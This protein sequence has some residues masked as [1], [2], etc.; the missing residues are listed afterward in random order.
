MS[1]TDQA[2]T[3]DAGM[4]GGPPGPHVRV[5]LAISVVALAVAVAVA[6][7]TSGPIG[8]WGLFP[9]LVYAVLVL[10]EFNVLLATGVALVVA[11]VISRT[12]PIAVGSLL[13]ESLGSFIAVVGLIIMLGAGLGRVA[14]ETGAARTLVTMLLRG[15]G[16]ESPARAQVGIMLASTILVGALGTLSGANAI[17]A[18]LA[19]PVA[20]AVGR[21]KPSVAVMLHS[22]GAA[23]LVIGPFTPPVVTITGASELSYGAYLLQVGL[24]MAVVVWGVGF[25]MARV[26]HRRTADDQYPA[27]LTAGDDLSRPIE[28][29][30]RRAAVGFIGSLVLM[31]ILGVTIKAG[32]SYAIVVM[33]VATVVT[34]LAGSMGVARALQAFFA[35]AASL[36]WLFFLFWMFNPL[37]VVMEESGAYQ[38]VVD[39]AQPFM[40]GV[41]PW[42]F[43]MLVLL[44]GWIGI[45]GAAVAQ[46]VLIDKLFA[47]I[48]AGLGIPPVAWAA[49]LL[50]GS[51]IDWFGPLPN[52]DMIGQM[53]LARSS[54]LRMMLLNGWTIMGCTLLLF[55][56]LF[57]VVL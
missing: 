2:G 22:A 15:V 32:F 18:P 45:S 34:A 50:G 33:L 46:V 54:N 16:T 37:L 49:A 8:L 10:I 17:L 39:A 29:R 1:S 12:G 41:G 36:I 23:G 57:L 43:L 40:E 31:T 48:A 24:P 4:V 56:G 11:L 19:I 5:A 14:A 44:I 9:I 27:E 28:P 47:P 52:A 25:L 42:G 13:S 3:L 7:A 26:I 20:A 21:S 53:G 35:G 6:L 38:I 51:Q 30:E 55:A